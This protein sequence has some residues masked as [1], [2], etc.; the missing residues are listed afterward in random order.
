MEL[1]QEQVTFRGGL[2]E[3][4]HVLGKHAGRLSVDKQFDHVTGME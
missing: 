3:N 1:R 2:T 4:A